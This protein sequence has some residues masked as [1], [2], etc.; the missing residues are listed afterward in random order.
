MYKDQCL[1][2]LRLLFLLEGFIMADKK[3][4]GAA[5]RKGFVAKAPIRC[6]MKAEGANLVAEG[7]LDLL[8][9]KLEEVAK[10]TTKKA[11]DFAA[12]DKRKRITG[13]DITYASK[14]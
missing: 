13:A 6:L 14:K 4:K 3:A 5:D 1:V 7:A 11:L 10:A 8:I 12:A 9:G 2:I